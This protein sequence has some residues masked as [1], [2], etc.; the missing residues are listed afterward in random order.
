MGNSKNKHKRQPL[1]YQGPGAYEIEMS[2]NNKLF[3]GPY[4]DVYIV[5]RKLDKKMFAM[6]VPR[7]DVNMLQPYETKVQDKD[8]DVYR[9]IDHPFVTP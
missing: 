4:D 9:K 5:T 8:R 1:L 3:E 6:K 7:I 2:D